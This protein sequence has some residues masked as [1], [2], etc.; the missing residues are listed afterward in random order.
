MVMMDFSLMIRLYSIGTVLLLATLFAI[1]FFVE[2]AENSIKNDARTK[3]L[4]DQ[5]GFIKLFLKFGMK[6]IPFIAITRT[7]ILTNKTI[8]ANFKRR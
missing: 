3:H 4:V 1:G 8:T 7:I 6:I 2:Q 5:A